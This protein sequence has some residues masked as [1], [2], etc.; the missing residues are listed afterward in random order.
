MNF[1]RMKRLAINLTAAAI[2]V[3]VC[4]L[5]VAALKH[6]WTTDCLELRAIWTTWEQWDKNGKPHNERLMDFMNSCNDV[7]VVTQ[8]F[9][10]EGTVYHGQ[11]ELVRRR[12]ARDTRL[13]ITT[14]GILFCV[15]RDGSSEL[16][17]GFGPLH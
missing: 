10:I 11:F 9:E 1:S 17:K 16:V 15:K 14:N 2:V 7:I 8:A 3:L 13:L 12:S 4:L 6:R 5:W